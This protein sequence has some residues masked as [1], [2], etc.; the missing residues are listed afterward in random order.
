YNLMDI[1]VV[2]TEFFS[3]L[4][5]VASLVPIFE[6][7]SGW[8]LIIRITVLAITIFFAVLII[9]SVLAEIK[10]KEA[11]I[12]RREEVESLNK[13]LKKVSKELE[14][15]NI[16]LGKLLEMRSEFLDIASHQLKTPVSVIL[17]TS[18]MFREGTMDKLSKEEQAHFIDNIFQKA[19]KLNSI[20]SDILRASEMDTEEFKLDEKII[21]PT[22]LEEVAES[23]Y[24]DLKDLAKE[25][26]LEFSLVKPEKPLPQI[27][28]DPDFLS[29]AI[30]NLADNAIKYTAKGSVKM[31]LSEDKGRVILKVSDTGIGIPSTDQK[32]MFDKFARAKNAVNMYTDGSGLGL[33]IVKKI[34]EAHPGG[35]IGFESQEN[36]GTTFAISFPG[37]KK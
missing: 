15:K 21:H 26:G 7:K 11:E 33:F 36:K 16:H 27:M 19:K 32:R 8:E 28:A 24:E 35:K 29:H 34:T 10:R 18:S 37:L 30:F 17:G 3:G 25:K 6:A 31:A 20:I 5:I 23:V 4:L 2:A 1:K 9:R 13:Q 22:P 14:K 12:K